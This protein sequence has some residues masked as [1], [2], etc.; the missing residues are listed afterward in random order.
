MS[1]KHTQEMVN[2]LREFSAADSNARKMPDYANSPDF[3][4]L[5]SAAARARYAL[6]LIP[7][8][9]AEGR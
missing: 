6:S 8:V 4:A 3:A 9:E 1:T 5:R 2:A 7:S